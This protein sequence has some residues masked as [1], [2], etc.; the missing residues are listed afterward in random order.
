VKT[1]MRALSGVG[2]EHDAIHGAFIARIVIIT[3]YCRPIARQ[4]CSRC[5]NFA[6]RSGA[7]FG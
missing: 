4:E 2:S 3:T 6:I 7:L 5:L 1:R